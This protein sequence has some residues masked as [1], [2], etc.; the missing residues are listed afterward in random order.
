M[1]TRRTLLYNESDSSH[2]CKLVE[3]CFIMKATSTQFGDPMNPNLDLFLQASQVSSEISFVSQYL[4]LGPMP[5][6]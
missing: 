3:L 2:L 4:S 6:Q 1:Q 5:V